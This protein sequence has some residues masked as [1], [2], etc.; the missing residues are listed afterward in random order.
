MT[1]RRMKKVKNIR[2]DEHKEKL[3]AR[4]NRRD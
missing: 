4:R 1:I 2:E 3:I